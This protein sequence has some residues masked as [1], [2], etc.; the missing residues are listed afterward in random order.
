[1]LYD[2]AGKVTFLNKDTYAT[3]D[4]VEDQMRTLGRLHGRF[5]KSTDPD[6]LALKVWGEGF[7]EYIG[8]FRRSTFGESDLTADRQRCATLKQHAETGGKPARA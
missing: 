1:M 4:M 5:Y 3:R 6:F 7:E 8:S 2:L